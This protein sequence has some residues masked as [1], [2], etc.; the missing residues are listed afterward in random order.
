MQR[1]LRE[2]RGEDAGGLLRNEGE[3]FSQ[4]LSSAPISLSL[5]PAAK[6]VA[7]RQQLRRLAAFSSRLAEELRDLEA[8]E[9]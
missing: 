8:A 7:K 5:S 1:N 4:A 2:G 9:A 6:A 3:S